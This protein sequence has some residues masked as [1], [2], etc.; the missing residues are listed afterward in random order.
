MLCPISAPL[1]VLFKVLTPTDE[2]VIVSLSDRILTLLPG[3]KLLNSKV[4]VSPT[5]LYPV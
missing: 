5:T 3:T 2:I 4:V 1:P